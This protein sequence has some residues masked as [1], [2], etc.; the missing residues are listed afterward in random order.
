MRRT[1]SRVAALT[2]SGREKARDTVERWTPAAFATSSMLSSAMLCP[3]LG[4]LVGTPDDAHDVL[5]LAQG[6]Q[7]AE[8]L[9]ERSSDLPHERVV[10]GIAVH[11]EHGSLRAPPQRRDRGQ[12]TRADG[13]VSGFACR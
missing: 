1:C 9:A 5:Q 8:P 4:E 2:A 7:P 3:F 12:P 13:G 6:R 11:V 10:E